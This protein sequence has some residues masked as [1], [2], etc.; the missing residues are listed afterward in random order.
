MAEHFSDWPLW[1]GGGTSPDDWPM[2]SDALRN[3]LLDWQRF[4]DLHFDLDLG[5]VEG[6]EARFV[7][8]GHRL[9]EL[10]R[11]ELAGTYEVQLVV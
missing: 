7:T 5:W 9:C 6:A 2:L 4:W 1:E 10:L 8:Q 11:R 3:E